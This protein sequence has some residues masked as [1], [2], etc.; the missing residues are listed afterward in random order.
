M[1]EPLFDIFGNL[2]V[3]IISKVFLSVKYYAIFVFYE[4]VFVFGVDD[5]KNES[6]NNCKKKDFRLKTPIV[7][8]VSI[9]YPT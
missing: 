3:C 2:F 7:L 8:N 9:H 1:F 5:I 4:F 6:Y